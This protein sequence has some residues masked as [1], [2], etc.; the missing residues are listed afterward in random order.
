MISWLFLPI[1]PTLPPSCHS[2]SLCSLY[3]AGVISIF[4]RLWQAASWQICDAV[5]SAAATFSHSL[6][7]FRAALALWM[8]RATL[9]F[10][11]TEEFAWKL[12]RKRCPRSLPGRS[13]LVLRS[14]FVLDFSILT[15]RGWAMAPP[16]TQM[17]YISFFFVSFFL[18]IHHHLPNHFLHNSDSSSIFAKSRRSNWMTLM[19]L[20]AFV[21]RVEM[22]LRWWRF[23][24]AKTIPMWPFATRRVRRRILWLQ[25]GCDLS[26]LRTIV[27]L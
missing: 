20:G 10:C 17:P 1:L 2:C 6:A 15:T 26:H 22:S 24:R 13:Y 11:N 9:V 19:S 5:T 23:G 7:P 18:L 12:W 14:F 3:P 16:W 27:E 4:P 8:A 21:C 25:I